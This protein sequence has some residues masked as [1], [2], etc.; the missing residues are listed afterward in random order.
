MKTETQL[1]NKEHIL[2]LAQNYIWYEKKENKKLQFMLASFPSVSGKNTELWDSPL[3]P[4][5]WL[6]LVSSHHNT[7]RH[8]ISELF[9]S[10][11]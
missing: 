7:G 6:N 10:A 11:V 3:P 5:L 1:I 8:C 4:T 9:L 2:R